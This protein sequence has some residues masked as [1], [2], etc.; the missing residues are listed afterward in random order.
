MISRMSDIV[1]NNNDLRKRPWWSPSSL[2]TAE[3]AAI[4]AFTF[5]VLS[6]LGGST[7]A[8]LM[9]AILGLTFEPVDYRWISLAP[10]VV[11]LLFALGAMLLG[12][13]AIRGGRDE[14]PTWAGQLARAA[15]VVAVVGAGLSVVAIVA[16]LLRGSPGA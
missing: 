1:G 7:T 15:V 9:Q 13:R 11:L 2:L 10:P 4:T 6:L 8:T 3:A 16:G 12:G 14:A 5:A